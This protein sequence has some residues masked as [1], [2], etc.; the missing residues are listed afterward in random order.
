[1]TMREHAGII[2]QRS[3]WLRCFLG[4]VL[5]VI[6]GTATCSWAKVEP[7]GPMH[8]WRLHGFFMTAAGK[9]VD[10]VQITLV[11]DGK[12]MYETR[13][14]ASGK[15]AFAHVSGRYT[16]HID[17]SPEYSQLSREV[18]VGIEAATMLRKKTLYIV[19]GPAACSDDC[20]SVFTSKYDYENAVRRNTEHDR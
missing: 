20:S 16:L 6:A 10:N 2:K 4:G 1:M 15:F 7:R 19:A 17:K 13:T 5:L 14:D 18:I 12:T 9:P 8:L 3:F 11:R